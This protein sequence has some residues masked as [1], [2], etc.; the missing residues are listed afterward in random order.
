MVRSQEQ[1]DDRRQLPRLTP[2]DGLMIVDVQNDFCPG[3]A[4]AVSRGDDIVPV[5]N[6]WLAAARQG[7]AKVVASRDWHPPDHTSFHD[8]GGP[9][10]THCV[11]DTPGAAFHPRLKLP[12]RLHIVSKG[13]HRRRED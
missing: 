1:P 13:T 5:L 7:R 9:W 6:R 8:Q 11:Q 4:L 2:R 12:G 3:G 10:P